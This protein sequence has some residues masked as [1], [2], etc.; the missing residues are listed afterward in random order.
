MPFTHQ[1]LMKKSET[2]RFLDEIEN[3]PGIAFSLYLPHGLT[4]TRINE[5]I[6]KALRSQEVSPDLSELVFTSKTGAVVFWG[7]QHKHLVLPPFPISEK[8]IFAEYN[9]DILRSLLQQELM[10]ALII[11]RLGSYAVG[12]FEG[13]RLLTSKNGTGL[14]HARHKKGGSS[15][16]RFE[17][18][19]EKQIESFFTR[20]CGHV[21]T[22]L[23][24]RTSSL[25]H[26]VYGG[27]RNTLLD[28]RKQCH[29]LGQFDDRVMEKRLNV[30]NPR[31]SDLKDSIT[32]IWS[33]QVIVWKEG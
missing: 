10:I 13:E 25:N 5:E 8:Q 17:R 15:Q 23:E 11:I 24:P 12:V 7:K 14:V 26:V 28:F 29:F 19:R 31:Q 30:R 22:N 18:H 3:V 1:R 6:G 4:Q 32:Q 27:E 33:S 9:P 20:V 16:R 2:L 21:R